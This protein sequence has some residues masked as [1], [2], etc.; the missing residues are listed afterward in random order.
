[1]AT[2][3]ARLRGFQSLLVPAA[4]ALPSNAEYL[5]HLDVAAA[6]TE[7]IRLASNE[8]TEPPSPLVRDA[9]A[10]AYDDANLSPPPRPRVL[11]ALAER[12][13]VRPERVL[14]GAGSTELI[15]AVMRTFVKSG[16][17]VVL[18]TPSWPV[19]KRR[20]TAL[21]ASV[22]EVPLTRNESTYAYDVGALIDAMSERTKLIVVCSPNNPTG[23]SMPVT[24]VRRLADAAPMLLLDAAY[25]DFDP[26]VDLSPLIH[27][28]PN[29]ILSRTFSKAYCLAGLRLGY[30]I[31][32][33][34]VLDYVDRFLVPG[35]S[36]SNAALR[37][38]LA[39]L[40][41]EPY[42]ER[43][44][45][46][47]VA[48]RE[49]LLAEIRDAGFTAYDSGGN[50]VSVDASAYPGGAPG[51]AASVL[52]HR[53]VIRPLGELARISVGTRAE[54]DVVLAALRQI[55]RQHGPAGARS[56]GARSPR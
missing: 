21:E 23:N 18:P 36:V 16:D 1:V 53:V 12:F 10:H 22:V 40:A 8:N 52:E 49:R 27:E 46:R 56:P 42:H 31:G 51:L 54:N 44:V 2:D 3:N 33:G 50:F 26:E 45:T 32:D 30:I 48:E 35:S 29:V 55:S 6:D 5:A 25:A 14:V 43:Q 34:A 39:A 15:E 9:L 13:G 19:F 24:D 41:D 37:G 4:E 20:L 47:I 11:V 17:E 28:Y 38:G 7:L